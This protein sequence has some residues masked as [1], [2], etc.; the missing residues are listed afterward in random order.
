MM[1]TIKTSVGHLTVL[2]L[3]AIA[4]N[5][6]KSGPDYFPPLDTAGGWRTIQNPAK[7]LKV[8]GI[9]LKRLDWTFDYAQRSSQHGG[10][11]V[12]RHGWLV[13]EKYY[14]KGHRDATPARLP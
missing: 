4:A 5:A 11:L 13:Y 8:A 12:V 2:G 7:A 14:G 6:Q 10:L 3:L 9:D 1:S